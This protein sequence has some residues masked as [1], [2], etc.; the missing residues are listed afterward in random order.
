MAEKKIG[1]P[2]FDFYINS[3]NNNNNNNFDQVSNL[4]F[5]SNNSYGQFRNSRQKQGPRNPCSQIFDN[6]QQ[7]SKTQYTDFQVRIW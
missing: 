7:I 5:N 2:G 6:C 4:C 3:N 1:F